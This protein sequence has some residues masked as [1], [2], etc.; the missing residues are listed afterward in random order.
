MNFRVIDFIPPITLKLAKYLRNI[1]HSCVSRAR[2]S[3]TTSDYDAEKYWIM[4]HHKHGFD[5]LVGVGHG[6]LDEDTNRAWYAAAKYIFLG[7]LNDLGVQA[8]GK[9]MELGYGTGFYSRIMHESGAGEYLGIDIVDQHINK[10]KTEMPQYRFEKH[11]A[12]LA[13]IEFRGCQL[14]YMIDVSQHIVNDEKLI[15]CLQENVGKNLAEGGVFLVT[16]E[17]A[18]KKF[19]F[20]E[21]SRTV[22]FY[23]KSLG[24]ELV[25]NPIQFRDKYIFAFRK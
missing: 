1:M 4:H 5:S 11:D 21:K 9:V 12:G 23:R 22:E 8:P 2:F 6:G 16:D 17:L 3:T 14:I 24:L 7:T 13:S 25:C 10:L 20:H 18:N 19:S 15:Y